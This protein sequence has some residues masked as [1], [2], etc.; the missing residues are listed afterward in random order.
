[1]LSGCVTKV[2]LFKRKIY[3]SINIYFNAKLCHPNY[4]DLKIRSISL[5]SS[6]KELE[7]RMHQII[8]KCLFLFLEQLLYIQD[9]A[10]SN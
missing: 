3:L 1:M 5:S 4:S 7:K 6:A 9:S 10:C 8:S 2:R